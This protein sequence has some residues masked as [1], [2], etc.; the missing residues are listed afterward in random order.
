[1]KTLVLVL[2]L[3]INAVAQTPDSCPKPPQNLLCFIGLKNTCNKNTTCVTGTLCCSDG[4]RKRCRDPS[5]NNRGAEEVKPRPGTCPSQLQPPPGPCVSDADEC[6]FDWDCEV[7]TMKCCSNNCFK[8]C[9]EPSLSAAIRGKCPAPKKSPRCHLGLRNQCFHDSECSF[10]QDGVC[11][12][13]GC[14]RRCATSDNFPDRLESARPGRCP[15]LT[16]PEFCIADADECEFD[17][18]CYPGRKCCSDTCVK[19]CIDPVDKDQDG[20]LAIGGLALGAATGKCPIVST[21]NRCHIGLSHTCN[22]DNE[23]LENGTYCCF[24]SCRRKCLDRS[25]KSAGAQGEDKNGT[26]PI[27]APPELCA[28]DVDECFIDWDCVGNRKCCSNGCYKVCASPSVRGSGIGQ[29]QTAG[30]VQCPDPVVYRCS[31]SLK[32]LCD[33]SSECFTGTACCFDGCRRRCVPPKG[34]PD[35]CPKPPEGLICPIGLRST[36]VDDRSCVD[37]T[38][39]CND[40]CRRRCKDPSHFS[41]PATEGK[42]RTGTCPTLS[43]PSEFCPSD[44]DECKFDFDCDDPTKKCCSNGCYRVCAEPAV[45]AIIDRCPAPTKSPRCH[46]GFRGQC[47]NDSDCSYVPGGLC[48]FDGCRRRCASAEGFPERIA[49]SRPGKCP[50]LQPPEFCIADYDECEMDADCF[51]GKKCCSN[52]CFKRC[53]TPSFGEVGSVSLEPT[54]KCPITTKSK[55]C[56]V[57]LRN[58]CN[59]HNECVNGTYCCFTGCRKQCWDPDARQSSRQNKTGTCPALPTVPLCASD[60]DECFMDYDCVKDK[61]CCYNGCYTTCVSPAEDIV[62][63]AAAVKCPPPTSYRCTTSLKSSCEDTSK[64]SGAKVCCFDG[65]RR[66]CVDSKSASSLKTEGVTITCR[67]KEMQIDVERG[68]LNGFK[69][70]YLNLNDPSCNGQDNETHFSLVA[71]LMGCG[72]VSSHTDDAVVYS[73]SVTEIDV[74]YEGVISRMPELRIPFSCYYTKEGVTSTFGIIPRKVKMTMDGGDTTTEFALEI[75]VFKDQDYMLPYGIRDFPLKVALNKPLY[76]QLAVDSPDT[77][78]ELREESCYATPT[79]NPDDDMK[80]F[81]IRQSCASDSTVTYYDAPRGIRR[82]SFDTFQFTGEYG[83]FVYLHCNL[84]VC[85]ASKPTS[86]CSISCLNLEYPRRK[87]DAGKEEGVARA[88]LTEGPFILRRESDTAARDDYKE[89]ES[90]FNVTTVIVIA[91][92]AFCAMCLGIIVYMKVK[93][94]TKPKEYPI[95]NPDRETYI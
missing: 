77:R 19:R 75:S 78:L 95:P 8:E 72:T 15:N 90:P 70:L 93:P 17:G 52:S 64:C 37:G 86:R 83:N 22:N 1:M 88:G 94:A 25:G 66:R 38:R 29:L 82:F 32:H 33:D 9:V 14:R 35:T 3:L 50:I 91:M 13:D 24:D 58:T 92:A 60:V 20:G 34:A 63:P 41:R 84:V 26:C 6:M 54:D 56:H 11:C 28:S 42:P 85:N 80:Y 57:G 7:Q 62:F 21:S 43:P 51:P 73:N 59:N 61:K 87:R 23:C 81:I 39:C 65:C 12:F 2:A 40:G 89:E 53:V 47:S 18:D 36:C 5:E 67:K 69:S 71:P 48:C 74:E 45:G 76:V 4:C 44:Y 27:L 16:K 10:I 79:Q 31:S 55:S 46:I 68:L 49:I 30:A